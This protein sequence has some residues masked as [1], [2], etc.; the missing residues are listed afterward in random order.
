MQIPDIQPGLPALGKKYIHCIDAGKYYP[1]ILANILK[2][3][4]QGCQVFLF[5][6]FNG[7]KF[8]GL[9]SQISDSFHQLTGLGAGAG[10][11]YS[12]SPEGLAFQPVQLF[13]QLHYFPYHYNGR[14]LKSAFL[15]PFY[16]IFQGTAQR[17]LLGKGSPP[18]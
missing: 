8:Y 4:M 17:L 14:R 12:F 10:Y 9:P 6:Y 5:F 1:F 18:Y 2:G 3:I 13:P 16:D 15:Y 11:D 7:G